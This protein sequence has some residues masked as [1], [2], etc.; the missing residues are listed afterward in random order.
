M[1]LWVCGGVG[2]YLG[3]QLANE[4][5]DVWMLGWLNWCGPESSQHGF[6]WSLGHCLI[7]Q[8]TQLQDDSGISHDGLEDE[9]EVGDVGDVAGPC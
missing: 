2:G 8:A 7:E 5:M 1:V 3:W 6:I 4:W 9:D